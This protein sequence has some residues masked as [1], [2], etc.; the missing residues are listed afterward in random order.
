MATGVWRM[1]AVPANARA[2]GTRWDERRFGFG[3]RVTLNSR[4]DERACV[5]AAAGRAGPPPPPPAPLNKEGR[6]DIGHRSSG[7]TAAAAPPPD[8]N[9]RVVCVGGI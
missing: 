2:R 1:A 6:T 4:W 8:W 3:V 9:G 5:A 7:K